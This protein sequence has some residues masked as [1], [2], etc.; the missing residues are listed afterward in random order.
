MI[1]IFPPLAADHWMVSDETTT[2]CAVCHERFKAGDRTTVIPVDPTGDGG[3]VPA[4]PS[5]ARCIETL[6]GKVLT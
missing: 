5:H 4:L 1:R 6:T 2:R 3:T